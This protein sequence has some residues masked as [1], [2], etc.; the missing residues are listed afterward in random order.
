M[1]TEDFIFN[2]CN[3]VTILK[4]HIEDATNVEKVEMVMKTGGELALFVSKDG[5][6]WETLFYCNEPARTSG[7]IGLRIMSRYYDLTDYVDLDTSQDVFIKIG[8]SSADDGYG[9]RL[10]DVSLQL[11]LNGN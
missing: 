10:Y 1:H 2:D 4:F 3:M 11:G 6:T 5:E 8:D 9:G 7:Y